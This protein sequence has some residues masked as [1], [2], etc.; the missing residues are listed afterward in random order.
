MHA[1]RRLIYCSV[2]L[3]GCRTVVDPGELLP[4]RNAL[5]FDAAWLARPLPA[6]ADAPK[7]D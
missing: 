6:A 2:L 3:V 7:T 4:M 5:V 1:L